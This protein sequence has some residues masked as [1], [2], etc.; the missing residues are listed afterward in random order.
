MKFFLLPAAF[1]IMLLTACDDHSDKVSTVN[2]NG[3]IEI[4][5]STTHLDVTKDL[6]TTHYIVW[7]KGV[8]IKEFDKRDTIP[9]LETTTTEGE[10]DNGNTADLTVKKDY[11]FY[12]TVK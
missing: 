4:S 2:R 6:L 8:K 7:N 10:D 12:V 11:E 3:G 5:L 1:I 9:A